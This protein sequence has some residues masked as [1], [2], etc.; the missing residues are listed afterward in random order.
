M[1]PFPWRPTATPPSSEPISRHPVHR[2]VPSAADDIGGHYGN[3]RG[4]EGS[5]PEATLFTFLPPRSISSFR[6][7]SLWAAPPSPLPTRP[8]ARLPFPLP[9]RPCR[10]LFT[11]D[12]SGTG[13]PAAIA[14][15]YTIGASAG[16]SPTQLPVFNCTTPPLTCAAAPIDLG[17]SSTNVFLVLF[18]TG[19][20]GR[21]A[22]PG[23]FVTAGGTPL[24]GSYAG[25]QST[26]LASIS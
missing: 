2:R 11:A 4:C 3:R 25:A 8:G 20:R 10:P 7:A 12:S 15:A 1:P 19:F 26:A 21:T 23:V 17:A 6:R 9:S 13:A 14:L 22:L 24:A 5:D 16:F 18:G